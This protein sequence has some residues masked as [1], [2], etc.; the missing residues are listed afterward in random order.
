MKMKLRKE[1]CP[2]SSRQYELSYSGA[3]FVAAAGGGGGGASS[4][5]SIG[6]ETSEQKDMEELEEQAKMAKKKSSSDMINVAYHYGDAYSERML[7]IKSDL[8]GL[9]LNELYRTK[10]RDLS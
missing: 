6:V 1:V 2:L 4:T 3:T 8:L 5:R 10:A 7:A 9:T